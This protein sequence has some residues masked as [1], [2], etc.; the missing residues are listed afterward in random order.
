MTLGLDVLRI[1]AE[2]VFAAHP[3]SGRHGVRR[4]KRVMMRQLC[5]GFFFRMMMAEER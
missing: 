1:M 2:L 4:R 5:N 3:S